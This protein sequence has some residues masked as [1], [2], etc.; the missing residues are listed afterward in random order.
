M[1]Q[2]VTGSPPE[3]LVELPL[4]RPLDPP[5]A[6]R[7]L[8]PVGPLQ[9]NA[10]Q[11]ARPQMGYGD[12]L[13]PSH[14]GPL[15]LRPVAPYAAAVG[16]SAFAVISSAVPPSADSQDGGAD[17]LFVLRLVRPLPISGNAPQ[18]PRSGRRPT[19]RRPRR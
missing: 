15:L 14:S 10:V 7:G 11:C 1:R 12:Q 2:P 3:A 6:P 13:P 18:T 16:K 9:R 19:T 17:S 5:E 4:R 8:R